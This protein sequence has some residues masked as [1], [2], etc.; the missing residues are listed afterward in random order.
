MAYVNSVSPQFAEP[1]DRFTMTILGDVFTAA[2]SV[3]IGGGIEV[4][5][6]KILDDGTIHAR[7]QIS[8]NAQL[9]PRDVSVKDHQGTSS[10]PLAG[11]FNVV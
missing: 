3:D 1:G 10:R 11:G 9:G 8:N 2:Q 4:L 7:L 5:K 6:F